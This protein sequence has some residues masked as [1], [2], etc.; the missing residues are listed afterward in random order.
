[1]TRV[2]CPGCRKLLGLDEARPD[3]AH[4]GQCPSCG[5][6]FRVPAEA[7]AQ[8]VSAV[9]TQVA[10]QVGQLVAQPVG[11]VAQVSAAPAGAAETKTLPSATDFD[12]VEAVLRGLAPAEPARPKPVQSSRPVSRAQPPAPAPVVVAPPPV[13]T[14]VQAIPED[15]E[16]ELV[17]DAPQGNSVAQPPV[18]QPLADRPP[19]DVP[20]GRL[21]RLEDTSPPAPLAVPVRPAHAGESPGRPAGPVRPAHPTR[22]VRPDAPRRKKKRFRAQEQ[23]DYYEEESTRFLTTLLV[24]FMSG[25]LW[26]FLS[27]L[28]IVFP[29]LYLVS[30]G[31][32]VLIAVFGWIWFVFMALDEDDTR[33]W[34]TLVP[35]IGALQFFASVPRTQTWKPFVVKLTGVLIAATALI[36]GVTLGG[37]ESKESGDEDRILLPGGMGNMGP[38]NIGPRGF[39]IR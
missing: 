6:R 23:D 21:V 14:P 10:Q 12:E 7:A 31:I 22:P 18:V 16:F 1:M 13:R 27:L 35:I 9:G 30:M 17:E 4:V 29:N 36:L 39:G 24:F 3:A 28:T 15:A 19:A 26:L 33:G 2:K 25:F 34:A 38:R 8:V 11:Q 5:Q 32:G 37:T 20:V